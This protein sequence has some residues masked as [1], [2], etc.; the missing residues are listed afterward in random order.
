[1][2]KTDMKIIAIANQVVP[3]EGKKVALFFS[4]EWMLGSIYLDREIQIF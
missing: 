3:S 1:M 2:I 4:Y